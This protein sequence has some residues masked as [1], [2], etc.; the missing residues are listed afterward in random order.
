MLPLATFSQ[1][2][3]NHK[4]IDSLLVALNTRTQD[5]AK[6]DIYMAL[7]E[8]Y[9]EYD[10]KK[11]V[12]Y[13]NKLLQLSKKS[14]YEYGLAV[15][16]YHQLFLV[17]YDHAEDAIPYANKAAVLFLKCNDIEYYL[18]TQRFIIQFTSK[19]LG[20]TSA[21]NMILQTLP[22]ALKNN[23]N[24]ETGSLF[25]LLGR[26]YY[27]DDALSSALK[28]YKKALYYYNK[29]SNIDVDKS[30]LLLYM[31]FVYFDVKNYKQALYYLNILNNMGEKATLNIEIARN[32]IEMQEIKKALKVLTRNNK[33]EKTK[34]EGYVTTSLFSKIYLQEKKYNLAISNL[35]SIINIPTNKLIEL[36]SYNILAK[37]F[38]K[39]KNFKKAKMFNDKASAL[40][41]SSKRQDL[42]VD[43]YL[44][45]IELA[46]ATGNYKEAF[47]T[48]KEYTALNE[49]YFT[50]LNKDKINDLQIGFEVAEKDNNIKN[51]KIAEL[52]KTNQINKQNTYITYG[53]IFIV[54]ILFGIVIFI[55]FY[56]TI[57]KKNSLIS[58]NN[59][60]LENAKAQLEKSVQVKETLLKEIHHRVKNNLQLVMSLLYIQSKEKDKNM[61]D[62]LEISQSRI[63]AMAL[64]H[65]NLY[66]TEDLSKV[67][68]KEYASSLTQSIIASYNNLQ[69]DIQL[70]IEI[71]SIYIDIQTAIPLGLII[72]ELISNAYKHAFVNDKKGIITLQLVQNEND[73]ELVVKDNGVGMAE[74][75]ST[76]KSLGLELVQQLVSQIQGSLQ[77]Q[78]ILGLHYQ[79]QF[80]NIAL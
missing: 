50:K 65:E 66:Q 74:K 40:A 1:Q 46:E 70:I 75:K 41:K 36:G 12:F 57:K 71:D 16:N 42:K 44:C 18:Y 4:K 39:L 14:N 15:Y 2:K 23:F 68:F 24:E 9:L 43:F 73:F 35:N 6:A 19:K 53:I 56:R 49:K 67:D 72:N 60:E 80:Q 48:Q 45:K 25:T 7:F 69:K 27:D 79:I 37:S 52:Q 31:S 26:I 28:C 77:V 34:F 47:I 59:T 10:K 11:S 22:I 63:I 33:L 13:N 3:L 17:D 51:L 61:D 55:R 21:K 5:T 58:I 38:L 76:K 64:I 54:F 62:F 29:N 8:E 30:V 78:D 32:Y 20:R